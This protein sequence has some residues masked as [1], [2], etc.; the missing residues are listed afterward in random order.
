MKAKDENLQSQINEKKET[1][2]DQNQERFDIE[3]SDSQSEDQIE[4]I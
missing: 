3:S 4:Q 2:A 1:D